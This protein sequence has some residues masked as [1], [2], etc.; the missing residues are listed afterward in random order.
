MRKELPPEF[1]DVWVGYVRA[2]EG[3][4]VVEDVGV[5]EGAELLDHRFLHLRI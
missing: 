1:V 3:D 5:C 2:D 4:T